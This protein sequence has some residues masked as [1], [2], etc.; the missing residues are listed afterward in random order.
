MLK[1]QTH[2]TRSQQRSHN[3]HAKGARRQLDQEPIPAQDSLNY[4]NY[5]GEGPAWHLY[6][7]A[8]LH[9][10]LLRS[11]HAPEPPRGDDKAWIKAVDQGHWREYALDVAAARALGRRLLEAADRTEASLEAGARIAQQRLAEAVASRKA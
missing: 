11:V 1:Q 5:R 8:H 10:V 7:F 4:R 6:A 3:Q 9:N 2:P